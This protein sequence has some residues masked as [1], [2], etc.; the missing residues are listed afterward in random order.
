MFVPPMQPTQEDI[1][2]ARQEAG[3][4]LLLQPRERMRL[5]DQFA[6]AALTGMLHFS[7]VE[8]DDCRFRS[9]CNQA[10]VWADAMLAARDTGQKPTATLSDD[11]REAIRLAASCWDDHC[12]AAEV[13]AA[14][15]GVLDRLG[16]QAEKEMR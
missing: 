2:L 7:D 6:A 1:D 11:E 4:D 8:P 15:R 14:L 5:R 3:F 13:S 16:R 9:V 12:N 10:F